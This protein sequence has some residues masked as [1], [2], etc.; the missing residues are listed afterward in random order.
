MSFQ[1]LRYRS[2]NTSVGS[3]LM[4]L[5]CSILHIMASNRSYAKDVVYK[6]SYA[7]LIIFDLDFKISHIRHIHPYIVFLASWYIYS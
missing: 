7:V 5:A 2:D 4:S 6:R 1:S 3:C